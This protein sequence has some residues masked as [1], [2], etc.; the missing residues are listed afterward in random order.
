MVWEMICL[1]SHRWLLKAKSQFYLPCGGSRTSKTYS[2][3][4][5]PIS[6]FLCFT[7][8]HGM[9][10]T[11]PGLCPETSKMKIFL[12]WL[13]LTLSTSLLSKF[14]SWSGNTCEL[15]VHSPAGN[16]MPST[17][18]CKMSDFARPEHYKNKHNQIQTA[19]AWQLLADL[20]HLWSAHYDTALQIEFDTENVKKEGSLASIYPEQMGKWK[21]S[22]LNL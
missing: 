6:S 14:R 4:F 10:M 20:Y 15:L 17:F 8:C 7:C 13:E 2:E 1:K 12:Y 5:F 19:F 16:W 21:K 18:I 9:N 11:V 22:N 3:I